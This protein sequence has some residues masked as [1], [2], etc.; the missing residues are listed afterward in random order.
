MELQN[1]KKSCGAKMRKEESLRWYI[2]DIYSFIILSRVHDSSCFV[3]CFFFFYLV[4][5]SFLFR[6]C[7]FRLYYLVR[8]TFY[9]VDRFIFNISC[10]RF[11]FILLMV[12][13]FLF[14]YLVRTTFFVGRFFFFSIVSCEP[15]IDLFSAV[16]R[17]F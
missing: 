17:E 7:F 8:T 3:D 15:L 6:R 13:F 10:A 1:K 2:K 5:T 4:R 12:F 14:Y 11:F 16:K 9:Y